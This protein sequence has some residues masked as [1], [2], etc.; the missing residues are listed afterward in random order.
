[1]LNY[2]WSLCFSR[3]WVNQAP[4]KSMQRLG[5]CTVSVSRWLRMVGKDTGPYREHFWRPRIRPYSYGWSTVMEGIVGDRLMAL[6]SVIMISMKQFTLTFW[7]QSFAVVV[8]LSV[9]GQRYGHGTD[10]AS[11][12]PYRGH[13]F[14]Y[15]LRPYCYGRIR[16]GTV[17]IPTCK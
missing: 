4:L 1:M 14:L 16:N 2:L 15:G 10:L 6:R 8:K 17:H 11:A 9:Y 3:L 13:N 12:V 5:M 7:W